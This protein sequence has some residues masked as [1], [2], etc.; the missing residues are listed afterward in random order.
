MGL[1]SALRTQ[2]NQVVVALT[3]WDQAD[4]LQK[5][6]ALAKHLRVETN[7][8]YQQVNPLLGAKLLPC[9]NVAIKF[10][11]RNLNRFEGS[12]NP[13]RCCFFFCEV[14]RVPFLAL[15]LIFVVSSA[16]IAYLP[17]LVDTIAYFPLN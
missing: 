5:L 1:T 16:T 15:P 10:K 2:F 12:K 7:A 13:R 3:K 9:L 4:Q 8:L 14:L 17:P 11:A 6:V